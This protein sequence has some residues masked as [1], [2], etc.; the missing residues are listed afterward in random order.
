MKTSAITGT[1]SSN[2]RETPRILTKNLINSFVFQKMMKKILQGLL[3][4]LSMPFLI[5]Y[6]LS[7]RSNIGKFH[8]HVNYFPAR[9]VALVCGGGEL[10]RETKSES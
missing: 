2:N 9:W 10:F 7:S 1:A 8:L 3:L 5:K 4:H 6:Y